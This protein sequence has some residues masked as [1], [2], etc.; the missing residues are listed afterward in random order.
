MPTH[1]HV[2]IG[3]CEL[4]IFQ[5]AGR[6]LIYEY[7]ILFLKEIT[8][9]VLPGEWVWWSGLNNSCAKIKPF[10]LIYSNICVI[11]NYLTTIR[12]HGNGD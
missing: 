9:Y 4:F 3:L 8:S 2:V 12:L 5:K 6:K 7:I 10:S 1:K 11:V